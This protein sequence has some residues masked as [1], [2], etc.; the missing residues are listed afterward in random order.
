MATVDV[1][2]CRLDPEWTVDLSQNEIVASW[3][4]GP[5]TNY[6]IFGD[7]IG[8]ESFIPY[9]NVILQSVWVRLPYCFHQSTGGAWFAFSWGW[10][11]GGDVAVTELGASGAIHIPIDGEELQLNQYARWSG[12]GQP[13]PAA[14]LPARLFIQSGEIRV[15][16][17]GVPAGFDGTDQ[18]CLLFLKVLHTEDLNP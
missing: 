18:E 4:S 9:D 13:V 1:L 7:P 11:G 16:M 5:G 10:G 14:A 12:V 15:S 6:G 2:L 8:N 3:P 17:V